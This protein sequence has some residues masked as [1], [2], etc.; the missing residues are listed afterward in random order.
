MKSH[1]AFFLPALFISNLFLSCNKN[2]DKPAPVIPPPVLGTMNINLQASGIEFIITEPGGKVLLDTVPSLNGNLV[3]SLRT[4]Q[5]LV[6]ITSINFD[7][8]GKRY[9]ITSYKGVN[10]STWKSAYA[11]GYDAPIP[12]LSGTYPT[13][14]YTH[15]PAAVR[16]NS[17]F[18]DDY[19]GSSSTS[20]DFSIPNSILVTYTKHGVNNYLYT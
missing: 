16:G 18:I 10:P 6:D 19:V 9:V 12:L 8:A 5:S 7:S 15:V 14:L 20:W 2:N 4:N 11:G 17:I 1:Y 3:A 13:L